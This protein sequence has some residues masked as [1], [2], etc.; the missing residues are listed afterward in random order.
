M[1]Q[2]DTGA[3]E[4]RATLERIILEPERKELTRIGRTAWWRL[5]KRGET[6]LRRI[7][8]PGRTG[9]LLS[10]LVEWMR[11]RPVGAGTCNANA[12]RAA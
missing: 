1:S 9:W 7:I 8:T 11:S 12:R 10:E 3:A 6:P 4:V 2:E 5:E